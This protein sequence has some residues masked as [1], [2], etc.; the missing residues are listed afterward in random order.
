MLLLTQNGTELLHFVF[1]GDLD[2]ETIL[3]AGK[4]EGKQ[5]ESERERLRPKNAAIRSPLVSSWGFPE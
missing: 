4:V 1:L 5:A 3:M 2:V